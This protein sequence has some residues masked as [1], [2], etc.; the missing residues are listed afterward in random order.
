MKYV[1]DA[2]T[3]I[4]F[5]RGEA[6]S[7]VIEA[8]LLDEE[9]TC[10]VHA[11]NLCEVYYD[12]LRGS[13]EKTAQEAIKDIGNIGVI[14]REDMDISLW[15]EAGKVK[16]R[17]KVSLADCFA[18]ALANREQVEVVTSD[19]NEFEPIA[20]GGICKVKFFRDKS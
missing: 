15:Q 10:L 13:D 3:L 14:T 11:V 18:I 19:H 12:F 8:I 1:L 7:D 5:L 20:N 2:C 6:G 4:A 17:G 9:N 16:A